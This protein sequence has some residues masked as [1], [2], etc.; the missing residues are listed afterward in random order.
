M[1]KR[2]F[3]IWSVLLVVVF[4]IAVLVPG[5][6]GGTTTG[7]IEVDATLDGAPWSGEVAYTLTGPGAAAPTI[8]NGSSVPS[9]H[10]GEAGDWTCAYVSGGRG[11]FV[12]ITTSPTQSVTAGGT[13]TF[14]L[15]FETPPLDASVTFQSWTIDGQQVP[16]GQHTVYP[17]TIIDA[18]YGVFVAGNQCELVTVNQT[19]LL[20]YHLKGEAE[21]KTLHV[22]NGPGSVFTTPPVTILSQ[23]ASVNGVVHPTCYSFPVYNCEPV[24]L[25]V[26][27]SFQ[28]HK[29]TQYTVTINWLGIPSPENIVF[30]I[31]DPGGSG[32]F[33]VVTSACIHV[34]GDVDPTNDCSGNSTMLAIKYQPPG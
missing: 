31:L 29:G 26:I 20:Q 32:D 33:T 15:N 18:E 3:S 16:D 8:I 6:N 1:R 5:C 11:R 7:T 23:Q 14:T 21:Q 10:T 17:P 34:E 9:S 2:F 30:D 19:F 24:T 27:V 22:A 28:L 4:S 13:I 25:D 12:D